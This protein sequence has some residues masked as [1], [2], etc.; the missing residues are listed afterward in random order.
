MPGMICG[1]SR[2]PGTAEVPS[3]GRTV[4]PDDYFRKRL[5]LGALALNFSKSGIGISTGIRGLRAGISSHRGM[6]A[7]AGL[8]GT[9]LRYTRYYRHHQGSEPSAHAAAFAIGFL[10][11]FLI[12]FA[13]VLGVIAR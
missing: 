5:G 2:I 10:L 11:P 1:E 6:Y 9:G 4:Q 8:P 13:I 3:L 7:S 12:I